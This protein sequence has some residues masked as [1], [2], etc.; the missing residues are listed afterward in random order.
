MMEL[1][2]YPGEQ[3]ADNQKNGMDFQEYASVLL[4]DHLNG[5]QTFLWLTLR[6]AE[7]AFSRVK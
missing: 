4:N 6:K 2:P 5:V 7:N 1:R 3:M